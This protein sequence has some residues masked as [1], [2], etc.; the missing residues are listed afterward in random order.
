MRLDTYGVASRG[1]RRTRNDGDPRRL[2][3]CNFPL[4]P[5]NRVPSVIAGGKINEHWTPAGLDPFHNR[6]AQKYLPV[7]GMGHDHDIKARIRLLSN[8]PVDLRCWNRCLCGPAE[9]QR[10][11]RIERGSWEETP[12][13]H[14]LK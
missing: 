8:R 2:K 13:Q 14:P 10:Y 6:V 12:R 5:V 11:R 4:T 7:V 1:C 9:G 3:G